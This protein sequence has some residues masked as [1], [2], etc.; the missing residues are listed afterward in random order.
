LDTLRRFQFGMAVDDVLLAGN[1]VEIFVIEHA[2][3]PAVIST[4]SPVFGDR[5]QLAHV[6]AWRLADPSN[7]RPIGTSIWLR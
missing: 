4:L 7:Y 2:D 1:L 3:N 6:T 5:D